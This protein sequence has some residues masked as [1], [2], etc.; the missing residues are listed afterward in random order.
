M[1]IHD[2]DIAKVLKTSVVNRVPLSP[3]ERLEVPAAGKY[4]LYYERPR[5]SRVVLKAAGQLRFFGTTVTARALDPTDGT[6]QRLTAALS[7]AEVTGFGRGRTALWAVRV[8]RAGPLDVHI[9]N[10]PKT[11][12][13]ADC[14]LVLT[15]P[16]LPHVL[17]FIITLLLGIALTIAG[18]IGFASSR[19][20]VP[21]SD[22]GAQRP[23][24]EGS[25]ATPS[26]GFLGTG[27]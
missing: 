15:K 7:P 4:L 3:I 10:L 5:I 6:E 21:T 19:S 8:N 1:G 20:D 24:A 26:S 25:I 27:S 23:P 11:D 22:R 9:D 17:L 16:L 13:L 14:N 12:A 18:G 2:D